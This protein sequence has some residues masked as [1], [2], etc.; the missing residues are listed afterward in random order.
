MVGRGDARVDRVGPL[1]CALG[2]LAVAN[3]SNNRIA[4]R[5]AP[6]TSVAATVALLAIARRDGLTWAD[7]GFQHADRGARLGGALAAGVVIGYA[8]GVASP[9]TR[10]L[11]L[12]ERALALSRTR[13]LEEIMVQVP[14]GTVLLEEVAFRGVLPA[15]FGRPFPSRTAAAAAAVSF[16]LWHVLPAMDMARANP[17]LGHLTAGDSTQAG[18]A[19]AEDGAGAEAPPAGSTG[20]LVAGTVLSTALAG[21]AFQELRRRGGLLAPSLT[22]LATNSFGYLAARV[23]R[24]L[25]ARSA[26]RV[27]SAGPAAGSAHRWSR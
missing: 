20:R 13:L 23:A 27:R 8:A 3:V 5:W 12:D 22:H 11:F 17:A 21:T 7:L 10:P 1:V 19:G 24:K 26:S 18:G 15:L 4:R 16:G 25:D 14:L 9:R 6:V 2:V